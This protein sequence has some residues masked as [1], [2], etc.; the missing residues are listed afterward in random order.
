MAS[1]DGLNRF[2]VSQ[3]QMAWLR[4]PLGLSSI[5]AEEA[6]QILTSLN[7]PASSKPVVKASERSV[8]ITNVSLRSLAELCLR[9]TTAKDILWHIAEAPVQFEKQLTQFIESQAWELLHL[10]GQRVSLRCVAKTS[11]LFHSGLL[12]ERLAAVLTGRGIGIASAEQPAVSTVELR[13][14]RDIAS[15]SVS[16]AGES[17]GHRGYRA[18]LGHAAPLNENIAAACIRHAQ[19]FA[20]SLGLPSGINRMYVPFAGTG[21]LGFEGLL[22]SAGIAPCVF[23]RQFACETFF[24]EFERTFAHVRKRAAETVAGAPECVIEFVER[25]ESLC[26]SIRANMAAVSRALPFL[27]PQST[28]S[29]ADFF[30]FEP[31]PA[32]DSPL[33]VFINPPYGERLETR[34]SFYPELYDRLRV[35]ADRAKIPIWGFVL[36]PSDGTNVKSDSHWRFSTLRVTQGGLSVDCKAFCYTP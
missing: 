32:E 20:S 22:Q 9:T 21:T 16:L 13:I 24:P 35:L 1:R 11:R 6:E 3:P 36:E 34:K 33:A 30:A 5:A 31:V 10:A 4:Y 23:P 29:Q 17:L 27:S 25:E 2:A 18:A 26:E 7:T 12:E 15:L 14:T 28:V 8:R 19:K